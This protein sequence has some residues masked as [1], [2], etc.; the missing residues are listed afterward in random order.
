MSPW[1]VISYNEHSSVAFSV[2]FQ[3]KESSLDV[4][5]QTL[6]LFADLTNL[7]I[8]HDTWAHLS[9]VPHKSLPSV[10]VSGL[11]ICSHELWPLDHRGGPEMYLAL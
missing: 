4:F 2:F 5:A 11:W 6:G 8:Y 1:H 9:G 7:N 3:S 10:C